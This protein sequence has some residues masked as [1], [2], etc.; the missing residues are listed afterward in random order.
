MQTLQLNKYCNYTA[1]FTKWDL[2]IY[3]SLVVEFQSYFKILY[4]IIE[5]C[6]WWKYDCISFVWFTSKHKLLQVGIHE[7]QGK[8]PHTINLDR[9]F[10]HILLTFFIDICILDYGKYLENTTTSFVAIKIYYI[11]ISG[12][13][14]VYKT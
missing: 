4:F 9:F 14:R 10:H 7:I 1:F 12:I 6:D 8:T 2:I 11:S 13:K 5:Y 3:A